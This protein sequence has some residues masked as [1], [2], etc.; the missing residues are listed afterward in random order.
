MN[1]IMQ[2][3]LEGSD[4]SKQKNPLSLSP[5]M[6]EVLNAGFRIEEG[7]ILFKDYVYFGPGDLS[8]PIDK[9]RYEDFLNQVTNSSS[10]EDRSEI[11]KC[12]LSNIEFAKQ[13]FKKLKQNYPDDF[14]VIVEADSPAFIGLEN[15]DSW[16][17]KVKF[18]K[19]R[20]EIDEEFKASWI[21]LF[22]HEALLTI[23]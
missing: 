18:Y 9:T 6:I 13:L 2:N 8:N 10:S 1:S 11:I 21:S 22:E 15:G 3:I 4:K 19:I 23:E 14:R 12:I 16:Q 7:C 5:E 20:R 17:C